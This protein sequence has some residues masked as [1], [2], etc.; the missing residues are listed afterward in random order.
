MQ[1]VGFPDEVSDQDISAIA[2]A[3]RERNLRAIN[4]GDK[5]PA[6]V[7]AVNSPLG[8]A[9]QAG[10]SAAGRCDIQ[11]GGAGSTPLTRSSSVSD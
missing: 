4:P 11:A 7:P 5:G 6:R 8:K 3:G 10:H 2:D 1:G 9:Q